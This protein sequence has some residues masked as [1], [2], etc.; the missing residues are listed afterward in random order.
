MKPDTDLAHLTPTLLATAGGG[1][2]ALADAPADAAGSSVDLPAAARG[3]V[4]DFVELAKPRLN[5]LVLVTTM[6]GYA[7]AHPDWS[8]WPL[9]LHALIGTAL[10]A[11]SASVLN[12]YW[13]RDF[14]ALM[15]RT[16]R[17]PLPAG[18]VGPV[19]ALAFGVFAGL[20][21]LAELY[22][23]VNPTTAAL[24]AITLASYV[25][26]YTPMKR[27]TTLCTV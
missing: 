25:F 12:Q 14:D 24:G 27:W 26:L 5:F 8:N 17:R 13:E 4:G 22:L 21:G 19:E 3:R 7:M 10:T 6:V 1:A 16:S 2:A 18:R 15:P 11:A 9:L 23:F 20:F